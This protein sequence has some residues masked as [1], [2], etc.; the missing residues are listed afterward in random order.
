MTRLIGRVVDNK[1][2][3]E[4][5]ASGVE[6]ILELLPVIE[7]AVRAVNVAVVRDIVAHVG[8]GRLEDGREPDNV[9]TQ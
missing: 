4:L 2:H 9:D 6:L 1:V 7:G 3:D 5:H 8:L